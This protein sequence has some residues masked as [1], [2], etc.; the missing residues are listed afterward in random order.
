[1]R[2][3]GF[4]RSQGHYRGQRIYVY[5]LKSGQTA[6]R[7]EELWGSQSHISDRPSYMYA[8]VLNDSTIYSTNLSWNVDHLTNT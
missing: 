7:P 2:D 1:M 3:V 5:D 6:N 4:L 8:E